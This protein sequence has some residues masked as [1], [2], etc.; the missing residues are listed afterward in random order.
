MCRVGFSQ[1]WCYWHFGLD[2]SFWGVRLSCALEDV[3]QHSWL[4]PSDASIK[5]CSSQL[6]QPEMSPFIAKCPLE[7]KIVPIEDHW[8]GVIPE[9]LQTDRGARVLECVMGERIIFVWDW[10][11]N[12]VSITIPNS[13]P[14]AALTNSPKLNGLHNTNVLSFSS[15]GQKFSM[16]FTELKS[17]CQQSCVPLWRF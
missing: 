1:E 6:W 2:N 8:H 10:M 15:I 9:K 14:I 11:M 5:P 4:P 3:Y 17:S 16:K 13:F 12:A 7:G